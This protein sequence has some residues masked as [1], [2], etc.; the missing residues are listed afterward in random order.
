MVQIYGDASGNPGTLVATMTNP[1][2]VVD[3]VLNVFTAPANTTL[4]ASTT[5]WLVTSNSASTFGT[6]F[7]VATNNNEPGQR[8]GSGMDHRQRALQDRRQRLPLD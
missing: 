5:Y 7:R 2:T 8:H 4:S 6:D 3:S 1:A